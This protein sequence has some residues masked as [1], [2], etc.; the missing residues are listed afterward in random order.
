[1]FEALAAIEAGLEQLAKGGHLAN[2]AQLAD[3]L[4][5]LL[6]P[7]EEISTVDCAARYR[8]LPNP[9][10]TGKRLYNPSLTPYMDAPQNALDD[11]KYPF[12]IVV[13][14]G[15]T[16]K[17]IGGENHLF[18]RLR[19]G[20]LT[21][22]ILYLPGKTDVDSYA[23]KEFADFFTLHP[24]IAS[25]LGT[26]STDNKRNFKRVDGR[27][28]Q[29]FPANPGTVRQKQAPLI[30]ATEIDGYRP[31]LRSAMKDL[32]AVRGRAYG[33][34][35]KGYL[36]SH[37][38]AGWG[39]GIANAWLDS[40][41]GI[42]YWPC[43]QC[44]GWSSPH[45]RARK[46]MFMRLDYEMRDDLEE[47][48]M[49]D[50]VEK[51]AN[52]S[53]PHCG[54]ALTDGDKTQMLSLGR[55]VFKGEVIAPD[56]TVT[57]EIVE[58]DSAGFWIHGTMSPFVKLGTLAREYVGALVFFKRTR[59]PQKLREVTV[60]S[61]GVV[62][63][64]AAGAAIQADALSE[65]A[66]ETKGFLL[67]TVPSDV[68]FITAAVDVGH[69][70]FDVGI[71]GWDLEGRSWLIDRYTITS[72]RWDDGTVRDIRPAE[73]IDD[74]NVLAAV[75]D[76]V[77]P[78]HENDSMGLP[79]A[80]VAI[81]TGD[82]NVTEKAREFARRMARSGRAWGKAQ[83]QKV[84]LIKGAKSP[85][86]PEIPVKPRPIS[87]DENGAPVKPL[88]DEWDL[89]VSRLKEQAV[90]RLGVDDGG[91]GQCAFAIGL[92]NS[93]FDEFVGERQID[94]EWVRTGPN[95]SLDLFAYAEAVRLM[96]KPDRAE[97]KW[98]LRPPVWARPVR[99]GGAEEPAATAP[100]AE[101]PKKP[102]FIEKLAAM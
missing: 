17:S 5:S 70:K 89:G 11:P 26:R 93:T 85:T 95:E 97:I 49:L 61:I 36:E 12:V 73:R 75:I 6:L 14:P 91:P 80:A 98:D 19:H 4:R 37:P 34:Q 25:R 7:P 51:T 31:A 71:W 62:Y 39:G 53:C 52:L 2:P 66:K 90:E 67:G 41:Q 33:N 79:V 46:G 55:W 74:W 76:R 77:V 23:D 18:K 30:M 57:G 16:G 15:R 24:E 99:I 8:Y 100:A 10:G 64:G 102:R 27:A 40:T 47:I 29:L 22:T 54:A 83:W 69:R 50:H 84:R 60:K 43:T 78:F 13:G 32:I 9:E 94:G 56:G 44:G 58:S 45:P 72:R 82:G 3:G 21:D 87:K 38:D 88:I 81:D 42:W 96:L 48:A 59:K 63:E 101:K 92:P 65:R 35:F 86:A 1:M 20:P 68:L 28:I